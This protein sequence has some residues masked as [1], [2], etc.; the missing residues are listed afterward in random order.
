M[1]KGIIKK[2][3]V[4]KIGTSVIAGEGMRIDRQK[5]SSIVSQVSRLLDKRVEVVL[6]TSGAIASGMRVLSLKKR[7]RNL[8]LQ[9]AAASIGQT[10]LMQAYADMFREHG[11]HVGQI[12]LTREDLSNRARY[13]N[14]KNTLITLLKK[15]IVP[16]INENDTV[17]TD[18]I[19]FGDNDLLSGLV[20]VLLKA[21]LLIILSD[22]DG[23]YCQGRK[24]DVI[25][26][27][28][29][30]L[31]NA[32]K[33]A[34]KEISAGGMITKLETA[35][36]VTSAGVPLIIANGAKPDILFHILNGENIGSLFLAK[37]TALDAKKTW[38]AFSGRLKGSLTVDDGAKQVLCGAG[39]SLLSSGVIKIKGEFKIG[40]LISICD[41]NSHEFGRGLTNYSAAEID[42]I[43]GVKTSGI[44]K[45]LGYKYYDELIHRD[46]LVIFE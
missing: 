34:S 8:P 30:E 35:K 13:L 28:N 17:S 38:I 36:I 5:M 12:L 15:A 43:K 22:V 14:A 23:L 29:H 4:I 10:L 37:K 24:V 46:N 31:V 11:R 20:A 2:R 33:G 40:D 32:C 26:S 9:Q 19:R 21:D 27:I 41:K 1:I 3:I 42:K 45:I 44:Q 25:E 16:V 6:V 39:R 7:P 18:E